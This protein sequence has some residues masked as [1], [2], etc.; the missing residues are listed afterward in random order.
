MEKIMPT[1][2]LINQ[3]HHESQECRLRA[4][5]LDKL[6]EDI[7]DLCPHQL[8]DDGVDQRGTL[9]F[10]CLHCGKEVQPVPVRSLTA[11]EAAASES[12]LRSFVVNDHA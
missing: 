5:R 3:L 8:T 1:R 7:R 4:D 11:D 9:H 6:I 12:A 2:E 10:V